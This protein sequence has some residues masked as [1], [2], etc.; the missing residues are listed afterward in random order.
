MDKRNLCLYHSKQFQLPVV[1]MKRLTNEKKIMKQIG[2]LFILFMRG[3]LSA[4]VVGSSPIDDWGNEVQGSVP[5][6]LSPVGRLAAR[7][8][9]IRA[10]RASP[11]NPSAV[12]CGFRRG[13]GPLIWSIWSRT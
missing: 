5:G 6:T 11:N 1:I 3:R 8:R 9:G 12:N 13:Y 7:R 2:F 10:R 4:S